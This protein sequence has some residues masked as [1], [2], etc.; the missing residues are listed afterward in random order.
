MKRMIRWFLLISTLFLLASI[1]HALTLQDI[2]DQ[3]RPNIQDNA[4]DSTLFRYTDSYLTTLANQGQ[5]EI[6][7]LTWC[8]QISTTVTLLANTS[9]YNL[10]TDYI[11][12]KIVIVTDS[13]GTTTPMTEW[14]ESKVYQN[15]PDF[16]HN[17][18]ETPDRYFISYPTVGNTS[19]RIGFLPVPG[20][21]STGTVKIFYVAKP[22]DLSATTDIPFNGIS[23]LTQYH[24]ALSD[25]II[26]RI[27]M[28]EGKYDEAL[29]FQKRYQDQ[30]SV[31][32]ARSGEIPNY[33]PSAG[34][35]PK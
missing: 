19:M 18:T 34:S 15:D 29:Y 26:M 20:A 9:Y 1:S 31:M 11:T 13:N 33:T 3:V 12:D 8:T 27:K 22:A 25:Y 10:P 21:T 4:T 28:I 7:N 30:I 32:T 24:D 6:N 17:G 2:I 5:R 35:A 23:T 16:E 14:T